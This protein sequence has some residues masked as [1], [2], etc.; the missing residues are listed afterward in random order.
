MVSG[1]GDIAWV[2]E[3][4]LGSDG[5]AS[6]AAYDDPRI[7]RVLVPHSRIAERVAELGERIAEDSTGV[8]ELRVLVV[9]RGGFV[10]AAD[11]GRAISRAGGPALRFDFVTAK[12]YGDE[13]KGV[14]EVDRIVR[15][16]RLPND[17]EGADVLIVDDLVDQAFTL[18]RLVEILE[19]QGAR[20]VRSCVLMRKRLEDPSPEVATLR[21]RLSIEYVG[22]EIPDFWVAGYG[23][24]AAGR[25]RELPEIVAVDED[26][27][28]EESS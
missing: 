1:I 15:V 6:L 27:C 26:R 20:S 19:E 28:R 7:A 14:G 2:P 21:Q 3:E 16:E 12:T 22:F 25:F 10:F 8:D 9:L 18:S 13:L 11:L 4:G 24:D 23:I 5:E 17:L